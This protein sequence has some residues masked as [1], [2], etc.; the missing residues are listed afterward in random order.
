MNEDKCVRSGSKHILI[1]RHPSAW[2]PHYQVLQG[3]EQRGLALLRWPLQGGPQV[4]CRVNPCVERVYLR[5]HTGDG[6]Q[7]APP[8]NFSM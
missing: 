6:L 3:R 5:D 4:L 1:C 7:E 8:R 2:L